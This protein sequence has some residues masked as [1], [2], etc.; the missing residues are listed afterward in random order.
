M[1]SSPTDSTLYSPPASELLGGAGSVPREHG[2]RPRR[3]RPWVRRVLRIMYRLRGELFYSFPDP[4]YEAEYLRYYHRTLL[5]RMRITGAAGMLSQLVI[6]LV[7]AFSQLGRT[8]GNGMSAAD[9]AAFATA[10]PVVARVAPYLT[11]WW[12]PYAHATALNGV[13]LV[14]AAV[15]AYVP[16]MRGRALEGYLIL[17][18]MVSVLLIILIDTV[19]QSVTS[20]FI[21][22][23]STRHQVLAIVFATTTLRMRPRTHLVVLGM[24]VVAEAAQAARL[25]S[26]APETHHDTSVFLSATAVAALCL[27]ST[28]LSQFFETGTR[29]YFMLRQLAH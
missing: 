29:R 19:M 21:P 3:H 15:A 7:M 6:G 11:Q 16:L 22:T 17:H 20:S 14:I 27:V 24:L 23:Q 28:V 18:S 26:L 10:W 12:V 2:R 8:A 25:R 5:R 1:W 4:V 9:H 13:H